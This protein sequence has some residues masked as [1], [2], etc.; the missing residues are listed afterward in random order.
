[1]APEE[2]K[3]F[4]ENLLMVSSSMSLAS[5]GIF[6]TLFTVL[7]SLIESKKNELK[8][9][10]DEIRFGDDS[11][12]QIAEQKFSREY[13]RSRKD[14]NIKFFA[15]IILSVVLYIYTTMLVIAKIEA[16]IYYQIL[17]VCDMTFGTWLLYVMFAY[18]KSYFKKIG[19]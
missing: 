13:I 12:Q 11:P 18:F 6:F 14:L 19:K 2:I 9:I 10:E 8:K 4:C 7:H 3:Q 1:M 16:F 15:T 5:I 17:L